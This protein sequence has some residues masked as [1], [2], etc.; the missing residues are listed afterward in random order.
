MKLP[1]G[2]SINSMGEYERQKRAEARLLVVVPVTV[3]FVFVVVFGTLGS[4][5]WAC[6]HMV[7]VAVAHIGGL[8]ALLVT[9]TV[10]ASPRE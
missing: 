3:F 10:S 5:K 8:L 1:Q 7:N 4:A 9:D 2:Y 6:L